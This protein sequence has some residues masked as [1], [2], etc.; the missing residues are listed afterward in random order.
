MVKNSILVFNYFL[1][2]ALISLVCLYIMISIIL[3]SLTTIDICIPCLWKTFFHF[4]CPGC[5]LTRAFVNLIQMN[6]AE[7][8]KNNWSIY[9]IIP[10]GFYAIINDFI[11]YKKG[12]F[13]SA[14]D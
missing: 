6:F 7:A 8:F 13:K 1:D 4:R 10:F 9:V 5:G 3:K 11:K 14:K 2:N 12:Y